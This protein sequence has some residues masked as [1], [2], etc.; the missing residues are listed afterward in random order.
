MPLTGRAL[1]L[2]FILEDEALSEASFRP[3]FF[4]EKRW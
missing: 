4:E 1:G 3:H 2:G